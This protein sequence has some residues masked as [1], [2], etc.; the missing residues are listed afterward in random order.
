MGA[1][2]AEHPRPVTDVHQTQ[3][4]SSLVTLRYTFACASAMQALVFIS[5]SNFDRTV[6]MINPKG[7][8]NIKLANGEASP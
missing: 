7:E 8:P 5:A 6:Y 1:S 2:Y 3:K 4:V